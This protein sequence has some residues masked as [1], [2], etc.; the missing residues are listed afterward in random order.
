[1]FQ[2]VYL[3]LQVGH[4]SFLLEA[5]AAATTTMVWHLRRLSELKRIARGDALWLDED[6]PSRRT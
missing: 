6:G 4:M 1:L 5:A 2:V 3:H